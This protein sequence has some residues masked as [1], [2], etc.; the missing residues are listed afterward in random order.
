VGFSNGRLFVEYSADHAASS[1]S[2]RRAR[3]SF[4]YG[5]SAPVK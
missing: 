4:S 2:A 3:F 5:S 1:I